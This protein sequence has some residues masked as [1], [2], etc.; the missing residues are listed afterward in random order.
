MIQHESME[1]EEWTTCADCCYF[2]PEN[3]VINCSILKPLT[4]YSVMMDISV[5]VVKCKKYK[6]R[7]GS[8]A[9]STN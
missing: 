3:E 1:K 7:D 5:V 6:T 4:F 9:E 2:I 8:N